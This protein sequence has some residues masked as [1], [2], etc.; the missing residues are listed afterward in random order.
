MKKS[1][2]ALASM[3]AAL[4][5]PGCF[6]SEMTIHLN[7][8]GSGTFV[9]ETRLGAQMVTMLD[10][11]S[12][13]GG[14]SNAKDDPVAKMFSAEKATTRASE[15]GT[16]VVFDKSEAVTAKGFKGARVTYRF[17]DI[18]TLKISPGDS[19]KDMSPM[20]AGKIPAG[21]ASNP[22]TFAYAD[23]KLT[24]KMHQPS[25]DEQTKE[26]TPETPDMPDMDTPEAQAMAKQML[27]DMKMS[28]QL[29]VEP[30]IANTNATHTS[31]NTITLIE[32]N[33]GKLLEN[34]D[35]LKK[36]GKLDKNNPTAAMQA[37]KGI[38]GLKFE[39]QEVVTV[40]VN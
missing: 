18:N 24:I 10:Q 29:V 20:D 40:T 27:G 26:T 23:S 11:M 14:N 33:M 25:T 38:K 7:K 35:T 16:G 6:Q 30:G 15:L 3:I 13:M 1:C 34:A 32:M 28:L 4:I 37:L 9:E 22:I 17:Q 21:T 39:V 5:L 2:L 31:G 12:A 36:L 19:M 8:D